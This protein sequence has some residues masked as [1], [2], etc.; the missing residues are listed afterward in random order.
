MDRKHASKGVMCSEILTLHLQS[1]ERPESKLKVNLEEIW[2]SGA[3]FQTDLP[4]RPCTPAW[5]AAGGCEFRGQVIARTLCTGIGYFTEMRFHPSCRWSEHKYRP[6]H[7]FNPDVLLTNRI[8]A[9]TLRPPISP[10][11]GLLP[12]TFAKPATLASFTQATLR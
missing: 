2:S 12:D 6:K 3:L 8:L 9:G 1:R 5:F 4:I 11:N 7:L 10:S